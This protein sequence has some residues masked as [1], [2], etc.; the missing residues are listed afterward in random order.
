MSDLFG[1]FPNHAECQ[2]WLDAENLAK[3]YPNMAVKTT[4][5]STFQVHPDSP[6]NATEI[7]NFDEKVTNTPSVVKTKS[8]LKV[9][10]FFPEVGEG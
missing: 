10:G 7:A 6:S 4:D 2:E 3:G 5:Y 1:L 9:L 8:E